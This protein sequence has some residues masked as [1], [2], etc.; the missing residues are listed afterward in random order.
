[1]REPTEYYRRDKETEK[2]TEKVTDIYFDFEFIDDGREIVP[3]SLGMCVEDDPNVVRAFE[4]PEMLIEYHFDPARAN[5]WVREN[6]FPH[7]EQFSRPGCGVDRWVAR[8]SI[9]EWVKGI[10]GDT[11]PRFWGYYPS[12]DWV[13]LC[14]HWG[15]MMQLPKGWPIRPG[16]LKQLADTLGVPKTSFPAQSVGAHQALADAKW[17]RELHGFLKTYEK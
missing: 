6:V 1:M 4:A 3:I 5:D 2:V 13:C 7:L 9:E 16:C 17:N 11:K 8:E 12:Y 15:T 14:Q 10:C